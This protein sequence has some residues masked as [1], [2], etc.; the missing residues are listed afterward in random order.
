[1]AGTRGQLDDLKMWW[2]FFAL[3]KL[4]GRIALGN[5]RARDFSPFLLQEGLADVF[6]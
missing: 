3:F 6:Y 2:C 5:K 4:M 1:M